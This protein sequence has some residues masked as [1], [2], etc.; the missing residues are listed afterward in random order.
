MVLHPYCLISP[1]IDVTITFLGWSWIWL[2]KTEKK[3]EAKIWPT[4]TSFFLALWFLA[5]EETDVYLHIIYIIFGFISRADTNEMIET[6]Y[7]CSENLTD[8]IL[9]KTTATCSNW[10]TDLFPLIIGS[11]V[12]Q[13]VTDPSTP[14]NRSTNHDLLNRTIR[15]VHKCKF[16]AG[17]HV[18]RP[19]FP[20]M[21]I[22]VDTIFI[23]AT[24]IK[25]ICNSVFIWVAWSWNWGTIHSHF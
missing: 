21:Y 7:Y 6:Y 9:F 25:K 20:F 23:L 12:Q 11:K 14:V 17:F 10:L 18:I 5:I 19:W 16:S 2:P 22:C 24:P 8:E 3:P 1:P 4:E 13:P 15:V